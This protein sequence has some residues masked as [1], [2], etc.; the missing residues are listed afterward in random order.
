MNRTSFAAALAAT[1]AVLAVPAYAQDSAREE[2][3]AGR[4]EIT[5]YIE[6]AQVLN[7]Q[8]EPFSDTVTYTSLA[9]GVDAGFTG[10]SSAG[11]VSLRYERRIGWS[12][13]P[14][15]GDTIS[16][17]AR[18]SLALVPNAVTFE[19]GGL[20]SR[21]RVDG[22]GG[23][24]IGG[25]GGDDSAT[26]QIYSVYAGPSVATHSGDL[27]IEGHYRLGYSRVEAPGFVIA[28]PT[29][30]PGVSTADFFDESTTHAAALRLGF[31]PNTVLP[32]GIGVGGD[33][34]EQNTSNLDQRIRDRHV[35]ADV[36]VP[37]SPSTAL[38]GGIGYEDVEISSRDALRDTLGVPVI[39]SDG[40]YVTDE[41][42]PRQIA[43][44]TSGLI[45]D[46][47]VL[48]RPSRR[49]SLE[50]HVGRRYGSTTYY[51]SFAYAPSSRSSFNVS[52]YDSVSGFGGV[53][54]DRLAGLPTQFDAFRNP[55]TGD[56][57]GCVASLE[58]GNCAAGG[59]GAIRSAAFRS[60]G[61][62][63]SYGVELGRTQFGIGVGYDRR[64]YIAA[65]G[66][67]I[68][69]INGVVDENIWL[70]ANADTRIDDR[71]SITAIASVNWFETGF[72][73][74]GDTIGYSTS[75][76]YNRN[77]WRGL[78]GT[79]AIG[80]DGITR[81]DLPDIMSASALLGL[82]YSF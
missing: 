40:R 14:Q 57:S 44:E 80:L 37:I 62:A 2:S 78:T 59:I 70:A 22:N 55:I 50:A 20:A 71:S 5:P 17:I 21:T 54:V 46:V 77:I 7:S 63:A 74:S 56:I 30:T 65:P 45:W 82:R 9:A 16:G 47:G 81:E 32:V 4:V 75:L 79:A 18:A 48:W 36:T 1:T 11:T 61:I 42:A 72:N 26:S 41:S 6:A 31:A 38:L 67:A 24:T 13:D 28:A 34:I 23:T 12:D 29:V 10:R 64:K 73:L 51:G 3:R 60:R 15:D 39:G 52:V 43:Y 35:R 25:F 33:W 68:A 53:L 49:T 76:A 19:A 69:A 66:S 8:L 27:Q 58:A